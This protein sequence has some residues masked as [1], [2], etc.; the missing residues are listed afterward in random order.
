MVEGQPPPPPEDLLDKPPVLINATSAALRQVMGF[1]VLRGRWF[2]EG[3]SA[4]V[5]NEQLVRRDFGGRDP[6]GRRFQLSEGGPMLTIVGVIAD[7]K[8]SRLDAPPEP[9]VY[10]PYRLVQ[11]GLFG[12]TVLV[13]TTTDPEAAAATVR[14]MVWDIDRTQALH[15]VMTLEQALADKIAPR[16][17]TLLLFATFAVAALILALTGIYGVLA[18]AVMQRVQEIGVRMTLGAQRGDVVAMVVRQGMTVA[19]TGIAAGVGGALALSRFMESLL[20]DVHPTDP[21]TIIGLTAAL[22]TAALLACCTPALRAAR[23]DPIATLR[24]E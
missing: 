10:V 22:A 14:T 21:W 13:R 3:E 24:Y 9:E 19:L 4:A 15:D 18:Y 1:Q 23:V 16:R 11:D 2:R 5:L 7:V 6:I 8:Y 17:L 20:Y 12:V